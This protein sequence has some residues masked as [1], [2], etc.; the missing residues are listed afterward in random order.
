METWDVGAS[1]LELVRIQQS[2]LE[3]F[4]ESLEWCWK[5]GE[6]ERQ[7]G[8]P[9]PNGECSSVPDSTREKEKWERPTHNTNTRIT[10]I[11]LVQDIFQSWFEEQ[12]R[13]KWRNLIN[14]LFFFGNK[15]L[16]NT[17]Y[18]LHS[19]ALCSTVQVEVVIFWLFCFPRKTIIFSIRPIRYWRTTLF[20]H[21]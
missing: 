20:D 1:V 14:T 9:H 2:G 16:E 5:V 8:R 18:I 12:D 13:K 11:I 21:R 15:K 7:K 3:S 17:F 6:Y 19:P 10:R 4:L